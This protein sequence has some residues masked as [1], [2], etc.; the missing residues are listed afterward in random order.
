MQA[1]RFG[2]FLARE[3]KWD[4]RFIELA[5]MI[6]TWSKD[7]S[8]Q[9]G[10]LIVDQGRR[11]VSAGYNGFPAGVPDL[12]EHLA[13]R[14]T[15]L[16]MVIHAEENAIQFARRDLT[17]CTIYVWPMPPC[18]GCASKLVQA[19]IK[20]VVTVRPTQERAERWRRSFELAER[21]YQEAGVTLRF[22]DT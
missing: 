11:L 9:C 7:P 8:T 20:T 1:F 15:K 3:R 17:D 2:N 5:A 18:A 21:L 12:P 16:A 4:R 14:E 6:S 10:A 19:G 13:D 22:L